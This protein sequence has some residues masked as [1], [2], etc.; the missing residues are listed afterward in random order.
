MC[1]A[2]V[3]LLYGPQTACVV[4]DVAWS[5]VEHRRR[6]KHEDFLMHTGKPRSSCI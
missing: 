5:L 3:Q 4:Q 1:K 2:A 6:H